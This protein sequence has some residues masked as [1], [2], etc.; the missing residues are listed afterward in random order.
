M[1]HAVP[2]FVI[3]LAAVAVASILLPSEP[4]T[5][6]FALRVLAILAVGASCYWAGLKN[7]EEKTTTAAHPRRWLQFSMTTLLLVTTLMAICLAVHCNRAR[8]QADAVESL[9]HLDHCSVYYD[10]G[11]IVES[12]FE[13]SGNSG[14][15]IWLQ[16]ALGFDYVHRADMVKIKASDV[17]A[18]VPYIKQLPYLQ[19]I[20][21]ISGDPDDGSDDNSEAARITRH[22]AG[23][24]NYF[25][26]KRK[27]RSE[28]PNVEIT[29]PID[30]CTSVL[31]IVG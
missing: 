17:E 10:G 20:L 25:N 28:L 7:G 9:S 13:P 18:A 24:K 29:I 1:R 31:P 8:R 6:Y 11:N 15:S 30:A 5:D 2:F 27:L 16:N 12:F 19:T 4:W 26:A 3:A 14:F 21:L 22:D 23:L